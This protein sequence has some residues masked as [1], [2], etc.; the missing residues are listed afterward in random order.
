MMS[1]YAWAA[2]QRALFDRYAAD[3]G[4]ERAHA[5]GVSGPWRSAGSNAHDPAVRGHDGSS[6]AGD[7]IDVIFLGRL[8]RLKG[9]DAL[10]RG[11]RGASD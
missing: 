9:C 3:R 4:C 7:P 10:V 8:T 6:T 11:I 5:A 2:R 1:Q